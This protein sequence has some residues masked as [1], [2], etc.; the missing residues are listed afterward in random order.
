VIVAAGCGGASTDGFDVSAPSGWK[1]LTQLTENR[2]GQ[3]LEA[4]WEG[5]KDGK[6]PVNIAIWRRRPPA[7]TSLQRIMEAGRAGL[8][9]GSPGAMLG[10]LVATRLDGAPAARFDLESG[11]TTVRQLGAIHGDHVY[12]VRLSAAS[13]AFARRLATLDAL[14]RSWRWTT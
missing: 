7:G 4:V 10:P 14:L 12:L 2:S 1:D 13:A 3:S 9:R 5:P 8:R 11:Q 6:V